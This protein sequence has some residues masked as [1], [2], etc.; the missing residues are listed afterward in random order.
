MSCSAHA[1]TLLPLE[2][3]RRRVE[4]P[5]DDGWFVPTRLLDARW[6]QTAEGRSMCTGFVLGAD[7]RQALARS[8]A[9]KTLLGA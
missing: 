8:E 9:L 1:A 2:K 6:L 3:I 5:I 4:G 7:R